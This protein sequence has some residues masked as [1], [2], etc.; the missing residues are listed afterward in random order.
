MDLACSRF[1]GGGALYVGRM[2]ANYW[3]F[4]AVAFGVYW[5]WKSKKLD[6]GPLSE[7]DPNHVRDLTDAMTDLIGSGDAD[8]TM[9]VGANVCQ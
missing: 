5:L 6:N 7:R 9:E 3:I 1:V 4:G 2:K 8:Q